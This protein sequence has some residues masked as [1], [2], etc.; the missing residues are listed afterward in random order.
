MTEL[1]IPRVRQS[2]PAPP[3][4]VNTAAGP[5]L[6][7][8]TKFMQQYRI[9]S[10]AHGGGDIASVRNGAGQVEVFTVGTDGS[11]WN[12]Y[13]DPSSD[14]GYSSVKT[15]LQASNVAAGVDNDGNIVVFASSNVVL[16]YVVEV[17]GQT[18]AARW[19]SVQQASVPMPLS[20]IAIARVYTQEIGGQL[21]VGVLTQMQNA[22]SGKTYA[23]SYS[24]WDA[25]PG[26]FTYTPMKLST[27][28][29]AWSGVSPGTAEFTCLD[30]A[31]LGYQV[32]TQSVRR[33]TTA[34]PFNSLSVDTATDS[35]SNNQYFAVLD[36][37]NLYHLIGGGA[38]PW[39]W[40]QLTQ[41]MSLLR[42]Q[43]DRDGAG[44]IHL[45][46]LGANGR[47][48]HLPP[49]PGG[50]WGFPA[51]IETGTALMTVARNDG[52]DIEL[53]LVG[54]AQGA[55][56]H[57]L[58]DAGTGD[59]QSL[60]L[61]VPTLGQVEEFISYSTD[62]SVYDAAGAPMPGAAVQVWAS[63]QTQI[64]VNGAT[65]VVDP[66]TPANLV[67]S[68]AG[69]LSLTQQTGTLGAA[70]LEINVASAMPSGQ[71]LAV[72]QFA[73]V[74]E[75]LAGVTSGD[76]L[77]ATDAGGAFLLPDA[78]RTPQNTQAL[79]QAFNQA[80]KL[81][82]S[83]A[84]RPDAAGLA[85]R[86]RRQ[87]VGTCARGSAAELNRVRPHPDQAH[88]ALDFSGGTVVYRE[89]TA[90][91]AHQLLLEK[92]ARFPDA[93]EGF[94][95]VLGDIGDFIQGVAEG[96]VDIVDTVITTV[97]DAIDAAIT[98][99]V[100][101]VT[102]VFNT[103]VQFV[104]Q[105]F[106]LV[107]AFFAQVKVFFEKVF[108]WLG[109]LF[110]W[111]DILRTH[112]VLSYTAGQFLGFLPGAAG[113][114]QTLVD[115]GI[116]TAKGEVDA[117]FDQLVSL[118]GGGSVGGYAQDNEPSEP[119][120][121]SA[122]ANNVVLNATLNNAGGAVTPSLLRAAADTGPVDAIVAQLQQLAQTMEN[123]P[124]FAQALAY[125]TNLGGSPDEIFQQL[126]SA[127]L[128]VVQG[129]VDATLAG[130]QAVADALLT[131]AGAVLSAVQEM[132]TAAWDIPF[133]SQFYTW[134]TDA[135][136]T[137]LDLL[138]LI[139]AIPATILYKAL[140]GAAPFPDQASVDAFT[141][142]FSAAT[143]LAASG[144]GPRTGPAPA[145]VV[146]APGVRVQARVE[147]APGAGATLLAIAGCLS[148]VVYGLLSAVMDVKPMLGTGQ[149]DPLVKTL[150]K[151]A[152][153]LEVLAQGCATPWLTSSAA[154]SCNTREGAGQV[155][156]ICE[157]LGVLLDAV[158]VYREEAFPENDDTITGIGVSFLYGCT[159]CITVA[160]VGKQLSGLGLASKIT[161]LIPEL[162]KPLRLPV[163]ETST[164]GLSLAGI[165]A[166]DVLGIV[167]S[168]IL[169]FADTVSSSELQ[170]AAAVASVPGAVR[171]AC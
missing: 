5:Q 69:T 57:L 134:L 65:Y 129:V 71:S 70:T 98:F 6:V 119:A 35:A 78:Y 51:P 76:L 49:V 15:G 90:E 2:I 150:S 152:L 139:V 122:M 77:Q 36:D 73:G 1:L 47:V 56:T 4:P 106:D 164:K 33:Y 148:T 21:Y 7:T 66:H 42:V 140:H 24:V 141:G 159:H 147:D 158:F 39:S 50:G 137:L 161:L 31:Y 86:A 46:A 111:D 74:Q 28:N 157:S 3:P 64:T 95:D 135:E 92:R 168:G 151:I 107:E 83:T 136:L 116:T 126:L 62:V 22:V 97:G 89:L 30:Q 18:G 109:F 103:V 10:A 94:L 88:W 8:E 130:V 104:E 143:M 79:A 11:V 155:A 138:S 19:G 72:R 91:S 75:R 114:I 121:T 144:L 128:R 102:Y 142:S 44:A 67:T 108:E 156:W 154:P 124:A 48:N 41:G 123:E 112:A 99:V 26:F 87:G 105:A 85:R 13:P 16:N 53:F 43:A 132:F 45:F 100:D 59:W 163:V 113:G 165:A 14:T 54:T 52:G 133:V 9:A 27:L 38:N 80:M 32:S 149:P 20:P 81:A 68:G 160:I 93:A 145:P 29:C 84:V 101:G 117:L 171:L 60:A 118:V 96:V 115:N 125:L 131:I 63:A 120:F 34:A 169:S 23:F 61:E 55:M 170:T 167:T 25:A 58:G 37:G 40:A 82:D 153:G 146:L 110:D 162:C 12:F 127:L 17:P 166:L